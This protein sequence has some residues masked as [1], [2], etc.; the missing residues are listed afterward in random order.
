MNQPKYSI[1]IP[2]YNGLPY[3]QA[4]VQSILKQDYQ[5]YELIISNDHSAD[6]SA[7]YLY[8]LEHPNLTIVEPDERLSM[9][10]HWEW[11]LSFAKGEWQIFVGQDDGL[12]NYFFELADKLTAEADRRGIRAIAS[13]RAYYF[14]PG[15]EEISNQR[16]SYSAINSIRIKH[17][18]LGAVQSIFAKSYF[19][20]PQMYCSSLFH[21]N[22]LAEVR[23]LQ[24]GEVFS[25]HPQDANLAAISCSL[26]RRYLRC[27]IPLGWIGSSPKS[28]GLAISSQG[29]ANTEAVA[30]NTESLRKEYLERVQKS[31]Y[32]YNKLAGNFGYS[33]TQIYFWQALLETPKLRSERLQRILLNRWFKYG[34]FSASWVRLHNSPS[35]EAR[36]DMFREVLSRNELSGKLVIAFGFVIFA[37]VRFWRIFKFLIVQIPR[38]LYRTVLRNI[39]YFTMPANSKTDI[40]LDEA[41]DMAVR[42]IR[43]KGWIY[44]NRK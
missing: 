35:S 3:L 21:K 43:D 11:A 6:G 32:Q 31:K 42:I 15:M 25:C 37:V 7:E 19:D 36:M 17:T 22:L 12:Q 27:E 30:R 1:I 40:K 5:N 9:T 10:E 8:G 14:W 20:L 24:G 16:V 26:E 41:G 38:K 44:P 18:F 28:A 4:C 29:N 23:N 33:D 39:I 34:L 13:R 2:V